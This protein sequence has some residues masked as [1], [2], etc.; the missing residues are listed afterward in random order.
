[1]GEDDTI[2]GGLGDDNITS[3]DGLDL[4]VFSTIYSLNGADTVTDFE[5]G[6]TI[7]FLFGDAGEL[8][9][10][11]ALRGDGSDYL[12]VAS[13]GALGTNAGLV[14]ITD[15]QSNLAASTART[16]AE[17]LTGEAADDM[18]YLAFDN[19]TD[20]AIYRVADTDSDATSFETAELI[21]TLEG[22]SN[23]D[24]ILVSS[25]FTDFG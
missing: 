16:I 2:Y 1:M 6:D 3:G 11:A 20:T 14:V 4:H 12:A 23:A 9:N 17:G 24:D 13:S 10:K 8:T 18:F 5:A 15:T 22:I 7:Q 25:S 21:V 19:G